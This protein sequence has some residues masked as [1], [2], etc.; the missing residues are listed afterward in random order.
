M[1]KRKW[2]LGG[3]VL[4]CIMLSGCTMV[5]EYGK[6]YTP[7]F[8]WVGELIYEE[9]QHDNRLKVKDSQGTVL[10]ETRNKEAIEYF[11]ALIEELTEENI[12]LSYPETDEIQYIY[13]AWDNDK[14]VSFSLYEPGDIL[15]CGVGRLQVYFTLSDN[16]AQVFSHPEEWMEEE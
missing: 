8:D 14:K 12:S 4:G 11:A 15:S 6:I 5:T 16:L 9:R 2:I 7:L 1:K 3:I 10:Y 13:E